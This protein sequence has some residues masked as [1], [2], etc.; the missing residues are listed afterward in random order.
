MVPQGK[1]DAV[2]RFAVE[3]I[4]HFPKP[5]GHFLPIGTHC[6][7]SRGKP[8]RSDG[9]FGH[10]DSWLETLCPEI[11]SDRPACQ[12]RPAFNLADRKMTPT[13]HIR[14]PH[15]DHVSNLQKLFENKL[16]IKTTTVF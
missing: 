5:L 16:L 1:P 6:P 14:K 8:T 13:H 11:F 2:F 15:V 7:K 10:L 9:T 12:S 3:H 4:L